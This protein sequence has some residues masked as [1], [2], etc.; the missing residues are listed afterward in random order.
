MNCIVTKSDD[1]PNL[2][3][4]NCMDARDTLA[5]SPF[6]LESW[7][8]CRYNSN[9]NFINKDIESLENA[10]DPIRKDI[11]SVARK[12][13]RTVRNENIASKQALSQWIKTQLNVVLLTART[14]R[15]QAA[16]VPPQRPPRL[17][18]GW[19]KTTGHDE[20]GC[21]HRR[22]AQ[23]TTGRG[24]AVA[25]VLDCGSWPPCAWPRTLV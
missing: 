2:K 25:A 13:L 9:G 14:Q 6:A 16:G 5:S 19:R 18:L 7:H 8:Q 10:M 4:M 12:V 24:G 11:F 20:S 17:A 15:C 1:Y 3:G 23:T 22:R 21:N